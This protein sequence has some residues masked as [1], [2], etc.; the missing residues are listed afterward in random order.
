LPDSVPHGDAAHSAGRAALL[1]LVLTGGVR[2]GSCGGHALLAA[3]E[4]CLHQP[5]RLGSQPAAWEF[6]RRLRAVGIAAVLSGSGPTV[7]ALATSAEQEAEAVAVGAA[8][9]GLSAV[10]LALDHTGVCTQA[11]ARHLKRSI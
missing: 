11:Q 9:D 4:D 10:P 6:V 5:Y 3:T 8:T 1:A 2:G 7:L